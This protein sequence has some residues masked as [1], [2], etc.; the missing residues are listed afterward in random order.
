MKRIVITV[1][2]SLI[3][4]CSHV[5]HVDQLEVENI[6]V[7]KIEKVTE[8]NVLNSDCIGTTSLPD[9]LAGKF[10]PVTDDELLTRSYGKPGAGRLCEG[11]VYELKQDADFL[12]YRAWN[13]TNPK[14]HYG[15]WW[16]YTK[17]VGKISE[18]RRDYEI[19]YKWSPLDKLTRCTLKKGAKVVIGTGQSAVCSEYLT[20][21]VSETQQIY[22]E[23]A[24][25]QMLGCEDSDAVFEWHPVKD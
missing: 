21:P 15:N 19:C 9:E 13:S 2:L 17:P 20:Y 5:I 8:V 25:E 23:N 12:V 6:K 7:D 11:A 10:K 22:I 14:S 4:A 3:A 16:A 24:K 18:Y 1:Q